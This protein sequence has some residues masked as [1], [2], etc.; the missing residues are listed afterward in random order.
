MATATKKK[1]VLTGPPVKPSQ[2][3]QGFIPKDS[4]HIIAMELERKAIDVT[5]KEAIPTILVGHTGTAK[6]KLLQMIHQEL[7]WP[8]RAITA[9]GQV[10]V[11]SLIGKWVAT[12]DEGMVY[13]LGILPFCMKHG[14]A[15]G[16]QEI[17]VV[18][19]EVLVLLHEYVD[20]G[21]IT[22]QDLDPEHPDFKIEPHANFRLYGTMN[23]PELYPGTRDLSPALIRRCIVRTVDPLN[24]EQEIEALREQC[25]WVKAEDAEQMVGVGQAVRQQF[26]TE[27]SFFW[28]STADLVMWGVLIQHMNPTEAGEI[29]VVGKAPV[30]EREF[31]KGR[32][33]LA[34]DPNADLDDPD[35]F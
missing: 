17:N 16:I 26:E 25:P 30:N 24:K 21:F 5:M 10:E 13:R 14:I 35:E 33:R 2:L 20:E 31:V 7:N 32:V 8:Y 22:L 28:L 19:P 27:Q 23:P 3:A 12:R 6:T 18:L 15:V 29:A 4:P 11:D 34:F 1:T 9:H